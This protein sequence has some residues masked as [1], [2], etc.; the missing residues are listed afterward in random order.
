[1]RTPTFVH[2]RNCSVRIASLFCHPRSVVAGYIM[3]Q[4]AVI[5]RRTNK[6]SPYQKR[7]NHHVSESSR[8][9]RHDTGWSRRLHQPWRLGRAYPVGRSCGFHSS[10]CQTEHSIWNRWVL[11]C[12]PLSSKPSERVYLITFANLLVPA[13][14]LDPC[15]LM[16]AR[17]RWERSSYHGR[18]DLVPRARVLPSSTPPPVPRLKQVM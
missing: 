10:S 13:L 12:L 9:L 1:M 7:K 17:V 18:Q 3:R 16:S 14:A 11:H 4:A 6:E 8:R 2:V 5:R 15:P